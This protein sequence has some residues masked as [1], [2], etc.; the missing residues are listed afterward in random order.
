M[1]H[2]FQTDI[3]HSNNLI[4]EMAIA[5]VFIARIYLI[6]LLNFLGLNNFLK[7]LGVLLVISRF[8]VGNNWK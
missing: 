5:D 8:L 7:R 6:V 3:Q 2:T 4:L 1:E